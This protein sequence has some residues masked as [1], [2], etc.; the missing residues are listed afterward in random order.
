M[1]EGP[2]PKIITKDGISFM[3]KKDSKG[4]TALSPICGVQRKNMPD[5]FVCTKPAGEGTDHLGVGCCM[6]H[7]NKN[8][9]LKAFRTLRKHLKNVSDDMGTPHALEKVME[10]AESLEES[11]ITNQDLSLRILHSLL[12]QYLEDHGNDEEGWT[13]ADSLRVME[14]TDAV[15]KTQET[16]AKTQK[17]LYFSPEAV[18]DFVRSLFGMALGFIEKQKQDAFVEAISSHPIF[19]GNRIDI[20]SIKD[21]EFEDI[22]EDSEKSLLPKIGE[23]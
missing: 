4:S 18:R 10:R 5:G 11:D 7:D 21:A 14:I 19:I 2:P 3:K 6:R 17:I 22:D 15:R 12:F 1:I 8:R 23:Y 9:Q 13:F 16:K 20:S